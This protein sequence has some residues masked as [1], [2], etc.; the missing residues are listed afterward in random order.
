MY[1]DVDRFRFVQ[2]QLY[3]GHLTEPRIRALPVNILRADLLEIAHTKVRSIDSH[4]VLG[5][6]DNLLHSVH[7]VNIAEHKRPAH[8]DGAHTESQQLEHI[9][10]VAHTSVSV[11]LD[12]L[13]DLRLLLVDLKGDLKRGRCG[14]ELAT[15]VVGEV[16]GL[17]TVLD[18][19]TGIVNRLDSLGDNREAGHVAEL[20]EQVPGEVAVARIRTADAVALGAVPVSVCSGI[21]GH[22]DGLGTELL[23]VFEELLGLGEVVREVNLLEENLGVVGLRRVNVLNWFARVEGRHV[24]N[25]AIGS[26]LDKVQLGIRVSISSA[27][28]RC[29]EERSGEVVTKDGGRESALDVGD[30]HHNYLHMS[31]SSNEL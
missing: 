8:T 29:D 5:D 31:A 22:D 6:F 4:L 16:D 7:T 2:N 30:I 15:T 27:S 28:A 9:S 20:A 12:L 17:G 18:G 14:V 25:V 24:K 10:T 13:E 11:H 1:D 3:N 19:K 26:A 21:N 23:D